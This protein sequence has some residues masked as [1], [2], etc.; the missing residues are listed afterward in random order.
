MSDYHLHLHPHTHEPNSAAPPPGVYPPGYIDSYVEKAAERGVTELGFTE[1]FYRCVESAP[2]LGEWWERDPDPTLRADAVDLIRQ[3]RNLSLERYVEVVLDAKD[4]GLPVKLGLE[5]D[6]QPGTEEAVLELL[7]GYPW[8]YLI[9][10]VHWIGAWHFDRFRGAET[11]RRRGVRTVYEQYFE[12]EAQLA[13][14]GL[15]DVLAHADIIKRNGYR[16]DGPIDD[17]YADVVK[18]AVASNTA[19]EVSSAGLSRP[20]AEI[21]PAP[22]FLEMFRAAGIPITFAS[23]GHRPADAARGHAHVVAAARRVGY[24][25]R[26]RFDRRR[27][28]LVPLKEAAIGDDDTRESRTA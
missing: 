13:A 11:F 26:L 12:L 16:P 20:A 6:F 24:T 25:H 27:P 28:S 1:H 7:D 21:Y 23:D 17:L 14:S 9:G 3:E 2:A 8:D 4:R 5:V 15:V 22:R 10:S 19:V 18:A